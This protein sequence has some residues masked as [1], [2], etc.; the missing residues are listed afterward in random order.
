MGAA[1]ELTKEYKIGEMVA[2]REAY[3]QALLDLGKQNTNIVVLD[4]DLSGSTQ[5]KHFAKAFPERF[6]NMGIAEM[7]MIGT[8]AGLARAG[9]IPFASSFAMFASGRAWEFVRNSVAHNH[10]NHRRCS[11]HESHTRYDSDSAC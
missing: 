3:G 2:T 5:T 7:N 6:F 10:L 8:A 4:A 9:K 11:D 1:V